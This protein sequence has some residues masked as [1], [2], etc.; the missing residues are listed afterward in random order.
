MKSLDRQ[1]LAGIAGGCALLLLG[2]A[3]LPAQGFWILDS[4]RYHD[5]LLAGV[6]EAHSSAL[7]WGQASTMEFM[8]KQKKSHRIWDIDLGSEFPIVGWE[9]NATVNGRLAPGGLGI[10]FWIPIGFHMIEDFDDNSSPIINTDY[11]FSGAIK[12]QWAPKLENSTLQRWFSARVLGGHESTHLGDEFTIIGART[13]PATFERINVSWEYADYSVK[14]EQTWSEML[15][16]VRVGGTTRIPMDRSYYATD[17]ANVTQSA[18]GAVTESQNSTDP[19][20]G[21]SID[22]V[23]PAKFGDWRFFGSLEARWRSI[24]NYHK[25]APLEAEDRQASVNVIVGFKPNR[26][27]QFAPFVRAYYGVNPHGQF[28]NQRNFHEFGAGLRFIP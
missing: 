26:S 3:P 11:R 9:S 23:G 16:S 18:R 15:W 19:Y 7:A 21:A 5:P 14:M 22:G 2:A 20:V 27:N 24:Y 13:Y 12:V 1:L 10:G 17:D 25:V 28:R 8:V 4:R 6:R